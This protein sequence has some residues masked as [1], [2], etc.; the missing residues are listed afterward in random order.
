MGFLRQ[1]LDAVRYVFTLTQSLEESKRETAELRQEVE[2][3]TE[4]VRHLTYDLRYSL[5]DEKHEREKLAL[6]IENEMLR[7]ERRLPP[8]KERE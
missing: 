2:Q 6:K 3:L 8:G 7:F 1:I 5:N 4:L